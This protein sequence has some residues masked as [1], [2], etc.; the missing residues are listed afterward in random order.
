MGTQAPREVHA[1]GGAGD[2]GE[3]EVMTN[4]AGAESVETQDV[5]QDGD[6]AGDAVGQ[7][8]VATVVDVHVGR[9]GEGDVCQLA[10]AGGEVMISG[11]GK[12]DKNKY[13]RKE[14]IRNE[15]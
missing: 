2:G 15:T 4:P 12:G 14:W 10:G 9:V 1:V 3:G 5:G 7:Q 8:D 13:L 6:G 11:G